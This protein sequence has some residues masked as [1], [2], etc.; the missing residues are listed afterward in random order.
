MNNPN[1]VYSKSFVRDN[2]AAKENA[3]VLTPNDLCKNKEIP[4]SL[5][6]PSSNKISVVCRRKGS[7]STS[8]HSETSCESQE[9]RTPTRSRKRLIVKKIPIESLSAYGLSLGHIL[10]SG[11]SRKK[12]SENDCVSSVDTTANPKPSNKS[13]SQSRKKSLTGG[14][15]KERRNSAPSSEHYWVRRQRSNSSASKSR[16]RTPTK[17]RS[18]IDTMSALEQV[19]CVNSPAP[20][21]KSFNGGRRERSRERSK[22]KSPRTPTKSPRRKIG[23]SKSFNSGRRERSKERRERSKEKSRER[24]NSSPKSAKRTPTKRH[25]S[26]GKGVPARKTS[27]VDSMTTL[28][29]MLS[30]NASA[31]KKTGYSKSTSGS[32]SPTRPTTP[33]RMRSFFTLS[34][35][36]KPTASQDDPT[37]ESYTKNNQENQ[38]PGGKRVQRKK[39]GGEQRSLRDLSAS[40]LS[41]SGQ[42]HSQAQKS[43]QSNEK[44]DLL[45]DEYL[46]IMEDFPDSHQKRYGDCA[47]VTGW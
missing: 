35:R 16:S 33:S 26:E 25:Y 3:V 12:P 20:R 18:S 14:D 13:P 10:A 6:A 43:I 23:S 34:L 41:S 4:Q 1:S 42:N 38:S 28:E 30:A 8:V 46:K 5:V 32:K 22:E 37:D 47:S 44:K 11:D 45:L 9:S 31:N 24:A 2:E 21:R 15:Q 17:K 29:Q 36:S 39:H 19:L 27:S 7:L 40:Q